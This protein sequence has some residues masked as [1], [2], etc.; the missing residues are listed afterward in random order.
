MLLIISR[1][2]EQTKGQIKMKYKGR[3]IEIIGSKKLFGKETLWI[4][5]MADNSFAQV[6]REDLDEED[7]QDNGM[8]KI[9]RTAIAARIKD[10]LAQKR[11]LAPYES[12]LIPLPHQILVLEK[13]MNGVQTRFLLADEVGMGKT[14]EAGLILKE[15]KLRGEIKRVLLVVPKSAMIQWQTELMEHF[16][17]K[18]YI[19]DNDFISGMARTFSKIDAEE[20]LNF[21]RQ[22]NQI[23]VSLDALKPLATRQGWSAE[24]VD[25]YN[26]YRLEMVVNADFDMIIID[27]AH[28][29][30]GGNQSVAR[31][32]MAET[33]CNA[34][35]NVLLLSATPHRGKSDHF[36]RV[37]QLIDAN[38]FQ[39]EGDEM[40]SIPEIEPYVMR[41]EKRFAVDYDGNKLFPHRE[42][43][44]L[45]VPIDPVLHPLQK[46]LYEQITDYVR[47]QFGRAKGRKHNSTGLVMIMFQK[48]ASSSSAAILG[49][50][51]TRLWRLQNG[52]DADDLS[53]FVDVE[54]DFDE[55]NLEDYSV[56]NNSHNLQNEEEALTA[57]ISKAKEC[58]RNERDAKATA[59]VKKIYELKERD[60]DENFKVLVFTEFRK[61]QEYLIQVLEQEGLHTVSINGSME[62]LER[63]KALTRF[64][65]EAEVM[66]ATDAAGESLNMQFCHIVFNYDIP[67]N[68]MSIEQRIGRVDRIGQKQTVTAYNMLTDN[69]VDSRVY[70]I[71]VDKLDAIMNELGIDK[72]GDVLDSTIDMKHVNH[73][74][75]QSLL[76]PKRFEFAGD[77]WLYEIRRKLKDYKSTESAL[78]TFGKDEINVKQ[79][80]EVKYSPLPVWLEELVDLYAISEHGKV[81]KLLSGVSL[82]NIDKQ[83]IRA[84]FDPT[85]KGDNPDVEYITLQH[86]LVKQILDEVDAD[87]PMS[88]VPV[89]KSK[90]GNESIGYLTIWKVSAINDSETRSVYTA[91]FITEKGRVFAPYGNDLWNRLVQ[92]KDTFTYQGQAE[93][94]Q[95]VLENEQLENN[96][97]AI[98]HRME[99][100]IQEYLRKKAEQ[101]LKVLDYAEKRIDRIGIA[102]IRTAKHKKLENERNQLI[103]TYNKGMSVVPSVK[104]IMTVKIDG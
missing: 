58:L 11:L 48:L 1:L 12:S 77:K 60:S 51:E 59:L 98:F 15:K 25:E 13:V 65:N 66:I 36:R 3:S 56:L 57:L 7:S 100:S 20:E 104:H 2:K 97:H 78:P 93:C 70:Q 29:V 79:A 31:F 72:T 92:E 46:E 68:P 71:I 54:E 82:Y 16:N 47:Y 64:R 55:I 102:N 43:I 30:G 91:Q 22:H 52:E 23:I 94:G 69:T 27:E 9:R 63:Q 96:L 61:T 90:E 75:L 83:Q 76:D 18:F 95:I 86:P 14:I 40:P 85:I 42:T 5:F 33:L 84:V 67:W 80:G 26:K 53:E 32:Q 45:D 103:H 4:R 87:S 17:E 37:L 10:E 38:A 21:W 62:L 34:V 73:L 41:S 50:L 88:N 89:I 44:R 74:Y 28:R 101:R 35:P 49:A 39:I 19:Y 24:R 6:L 8:A 99:I 81:E